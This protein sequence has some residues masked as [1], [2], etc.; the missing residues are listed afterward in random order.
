MADHADFPPSSNFRLIRCPGSAILS[1][2]S[3]ERQAEFWTAEGTIAH[4]VRELCLLLGMDPEDFIGSKMKS[5][6][7]TVKVDETMADAL[8]PGIEWVRD[9]GGKLYVEQRV[10]SDRWMPGQFGTLDTGIIGQHI[11]IIDDLKYG[12]GMDVDVADNEQLMTYALFFWDMIAKYETDVTEFMLVVDQ[13][14]ARGTRHEDEDLGGWG[15][16]WRVTLD[17]LLEFGEK[18]KTS[19]DIAISNDAWLRAGFKQCRMCPAKGR[20]PEYARFNLALL[21]LE[22]GQLDPDVTTLRQIDEF[23]PAHRVKLAMNQDIIQNWLK[24]V[25]AQVISDAYQE[26][27]TPGVKAVQ[28]NGTGPRKWRDEQEA[29]DF[30]REAL[31]H[32]KIYAP[33]KMYSPKQL[34]DLK[35]FPAEKKDEIADLVIRNPGKLSLVW[36]SDS[37]P[38]ITLTAEFD[39]IDDEFDDDEEDDDGVDATEDILG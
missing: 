36:D 37:R 9:Q 32:N 24:G 29:A 27:E 11:I 38:A 19:Y 13:P 35:G 39:S 26:K 25:H 18:L 15:G 20:C 2:G 28:S 23:T 30:M 4:W 1:R 14:R 10:R 33:G 34:E 31:G 17:E 8:R 3:E 16:E 6:G 7:F 12:A 22:L 21:D 5:D